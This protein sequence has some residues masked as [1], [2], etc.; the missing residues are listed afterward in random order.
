MH[1]LCSLQQRCFSEA[2]VFILFPDSL[3]CVYPLET[4]PPTAPV[5]TPYS[6]ML[7]PLSNPNAVLSIL[8]TDILLFFNQK[9]TESRCCN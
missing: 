5:L 7:P 2:E 8:S 1:S 3:V 6:A 9:T 4:H